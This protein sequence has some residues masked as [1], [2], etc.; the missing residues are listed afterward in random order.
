M[1][2]TSAEY[3]KKRWGAKAIAEDSEPVDLDALTDPQKR[4]L[5]VICGTSSEARLNKETGEW[6]VIKE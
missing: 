4:N 5:A 3:W 2:P 6:E 1:N